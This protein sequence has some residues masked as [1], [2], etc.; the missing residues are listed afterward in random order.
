MKRK[1]YRV[2]NFILVLIV[3]LTFTGCNQPFQKDKRPNFLIIV[4]DDQRYDTM[5]YMPQTQSMIF[6]QGVTFSNGMVTT[7]LC[8]PSRSSI[9]TGMYAHNHNVRQNSD[10][11]KIKT[12]MADLH[13]NGY[14]TGLV[15]KYLNSWKGQPLPEYDS[16]V[17]YFGGETN[18]Y[19]AR[20]IVNG[21]YTRYEKEYVTYVL[22]DY[23]SDFLIKASQQDKPFVLFYTPNAPHAPT[24]PAK[25]DENLLLDLKPYRPASFNEPDT[26]KKPSWWQTRALLTTDEIAGIDKFRRDQLLTLIA[27]DR[28]IG[29]VMTTL[30]D[31]G[32]LDNTVVVYLSDN[33]MFW[34]EHRMTEVKYSYYEEASRVPFALR[35][36]PL[37]PKPYTDPHVIGNIDIAP[38]LYDLAGIPIPKGVDGLSLVKL[39][40]G[41]GPWREGIL[42][43]GWPGRGNY[44][45]VR[46]ETYAYAE[47]EGDVSELYNIQTDPLEINNLV[48]DP[49]YQAV[50]DHH[51]TL[52]QQIEEQSP[53]PTPNP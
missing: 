53:T 51:H 17:S 1:I 33:G 15:G 48:G 28:A 5:D 25:E 45:A 41:E 44:D 11:L 21:K 12:F 31:T 7:S 9:L 3:V 49:K 47:T 32:E 43:E 52:L 26:S 19:D 50:V 34:G 10:K 39:L 22:G 23:A 38:T 40:K 14:Y 36:P 2:L 30:K 24:T 46:T 42:L 16:W 8:C 37:V 13:E 4:S 6:D 35:Y 27:L 20:L 29:K 18:Y